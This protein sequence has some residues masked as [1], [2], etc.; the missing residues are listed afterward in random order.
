M[1]S[2]EIKMGLKGT[3]AR[4]FYHSF[5]DIPI[6]TLLISFEGRKRVLS[7]REG[8]KQVKAVGNNSNP[9]PLWDIIYKRWDEYLN[10][11][12]SDMGYEI[13]EIALL[14]TGADIDNF[15]KAKFSSLFIL[16]YF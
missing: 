3:A 5:G 12:S 9:P 15:G 16:K 11:V 6:K 4:I 14:S 13:E 10:K 8:F 2:K 7:T 1:E